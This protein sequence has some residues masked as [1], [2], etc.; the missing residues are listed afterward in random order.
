MAYTIRVFHIVTTSS[1]NPKQLPGSCVLSASPP[2]CTIS[3][4]RVNKITP[5]QTDG[6]GTGVW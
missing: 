3:I 1:D 2:T 5:K 6:M 4:T